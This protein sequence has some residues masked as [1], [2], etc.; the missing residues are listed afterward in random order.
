MADTIWHPA[1]R[2]TTVAVAIFGSLGLV[3]LGV[4][5]AAMV[6]EFKNTWEY[7]FLFERAVAAAAPVAT[8]LTVAALVVGL[9]AVARS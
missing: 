2:F 7:Y 1:D 8:S 5:A 3:L 6:A 9:A 4:G